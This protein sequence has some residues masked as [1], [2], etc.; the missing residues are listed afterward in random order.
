MLFKKIDKKPYYSNDSFD[1]SE[2]DEIQIISSSSNKN[3]LCDSTSDLL[4]EQSEL[5]DER[6]KNEINDIMSIKS[7]NY[8]NLNSTSL[9][10]QQYVTMSNNS[11]LS[12]INRSLPAT[13]I[14]NSSNKTRKRSFGK[15]LLYSPI[16][17]RKA[18]K[19]K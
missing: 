9:R 16:M 18:M 4:I 12:F 6:R 15:T 2:L 7:D 13:P 19:Q 1:E 5:N 3:R 10:A 17:I 14:K 8:D 11:R